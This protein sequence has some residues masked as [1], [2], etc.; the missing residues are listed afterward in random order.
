MNWLMVLYFL[1][2]VVPAGDKETDELIKIVEKIE[3]I[4]FKK[5]A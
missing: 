3:E 4:L 1:K 5:I 2:K